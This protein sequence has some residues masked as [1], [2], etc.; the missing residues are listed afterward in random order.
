MKAVLRYVLFGLAIYGVFLLGTVPASWIY[1][2]WLQTR[3][4]GWT[5]YGVKGTVWEG[6]ATLVK[7]GNIQFENLHWDLH[8]WT[9][10]WGKVEAA[11]GFDYQT[12]PGKMVVGRSLTGNWYLDDVTVE[13]PAQRLEP[14]LRLPGA[15]LGGKLA[16]Q[17]SSLTVKQGRVT[18]ADGNMAWVKAALRKPLA[19][20]L[21]TFEIDLETNANGIGGAL[22]DRGGSVQAQGLF[23]L[24]A[25]GQYQLTAT[26]ASRDP[27]KSLITQGLRLFGTPGP[28]GRVKYSATGVV[29]AIL[30]GAG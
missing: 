4:G 7:S 17:L 22:I 19:V 23:K 16:I 11:L 9:L 5:L 27:Q 25:D 13:L 18:A 15:E 21:G 12:A 6:R 14:L 10:L 8:P 2:H 24:Q 29:P 28:D 30:P 1:S 3:L 20:E 26:F